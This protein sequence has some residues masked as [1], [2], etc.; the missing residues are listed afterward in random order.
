MNV[1][2]RSI[3]LLKGNATASAKAFESYHLYGARHDAD[4]YNCILEPCAAAGQV[5]RWF[6]CARLRG[7]SDGRRRAAHALAPRRAPGH[8]GPQQQHRGRRSKPP[9]PRAPAP[10]HPQVQAV[11]GV[12]SHMREQGVKPN[13]TSYN[14]LLRAC[15]KAGDLRTVISL[16]SRPRD[17]GGGGG[18]PLEG[19]KLEP[20]VMEDLL[21]LSNQVGV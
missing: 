2:L 20:G 16:L 5:G 8:R 3:A 9:P 6:R 1:L 7:V 18:K 13:A 10:L 17:G 15:H 12:M 4:S 14:L 11:Q 21:V 19:H